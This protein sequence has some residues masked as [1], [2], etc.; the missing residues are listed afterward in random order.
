MSSLFKVPKQGDATFTEL[1]NVKKRRCGGDSSNGS[2]DNDRSAKRK[3][4]NASDD[5]ATSFPD[6]TLLLQKFQIGSS[7]KLNRAQKNKMKRGFSA[8]VLSFGNNMFGQSGLGEG[9]EKRTR[10]ALIDTLRNQGV[11]QVAC[12]GQ[13][14]LAVT[15]DGSVYGW[16]DNEKGSLG[17]AEDISYLPEII[18][19]FKPSRC[20]PGKHVYNLRSMQSANNDYEDKIVEVRAGN[21]QSLARS[22]N[23]RVYFF[24]SYHDSVSGKDWKHPSPPDDPRCLEDHMVLILT[25]PRERSI[26]PSI[27]GD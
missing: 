1:N 14:S 20:E 16:G 23:G 11:K 17:I 15:L 3:K 9:I 27:F 18:K 24:G 25:L 10:P 8:E 19:G 13:H 12:G 6:T 4:T 26:G 7:A 22:E 5:D 2:A 21:T